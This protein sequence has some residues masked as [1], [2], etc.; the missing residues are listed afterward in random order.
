[1]FMECIN[2]EPAYVY[3][4]MSGDGVGVGWMVAKA[5]TKE[6]RQHKQ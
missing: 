4:E 1:M 5:K 2:I 3:K 6:A